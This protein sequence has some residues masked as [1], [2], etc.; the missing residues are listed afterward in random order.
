MFQRGP[1]GWVSAPIVRVVS[2]F[3]L[4]EKQ[5]AVKAFDFAIAI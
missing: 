4:L 2:A 1:P 5:S 3:S